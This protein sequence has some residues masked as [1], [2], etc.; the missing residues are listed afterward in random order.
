MGS[1][2]IKQFRRK[3]KRTKRDIE[4]SRRTR[5]REAGQRFTWDAK[6]AIARQ[7]A[8]ASGELFRGIGYKRVASGRDRTQ[9]VLESTAPHSG[10]VEHGTGIKGDGL[11]PAGNPTTGRIAE[12]I[13]EKPTFRLRGPLW[14]VA[15]QIAS[16]IREKGTDP[17]PFF[18]GSVSDAWNRML[19]SLRFDLNEALD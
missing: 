15:S 8:N 10:F 14:P 17:Q 9:V 6:Q 2:D 13:T 3:L 4:E 7:D 11:Y 1:R 12:W 5:P 18:E 19:I 16:N